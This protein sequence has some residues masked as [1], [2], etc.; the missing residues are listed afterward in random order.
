MPFERPALF[1]NLAPMFDD[2][3]FDLRLNVKIVRHMRERIDNRLEHFLG[4]RRLGRRTFVS[5]LNDSSRFFP[6][7]LRAR[8]LFLDRFDGI[9]RH[10]ESQIHFGLERSS[11]V[12]GQR[13]RFEKLALI[14]LRDGEV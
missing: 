1:K 6:F 14:E 5:S 7:R 3:A 9:E 4:D 11:V 2:D 12:L 10:L 8:V 13:S